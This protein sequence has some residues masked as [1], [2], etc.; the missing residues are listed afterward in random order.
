MR[1]LLS[2]LLLSFTTAQAQDVKADSVRVIKSERRLYALSAGQVVK[3]FPVTLG[4]PLFGFHPKG[5][6]EMRGDCKTPEGKYTLK[7]RTG[8]KFYKGRGF[9]LS[10]PN[11]VDKQKG[12]KRGIPPDELEDKLGDAIMI[13]G[14]KKGMGWLGFFAQRLNWTVGC[15]AVKNSDMDKLWD[16][17]PKKGAIPI[18]ILH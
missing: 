2:V 12:L 6:K 16:L 4:S 1:L 15:I 5:P 3:T 18:E 13:H 14:Q 11:A 8:G 9:L 17:L 10:Y 7:R